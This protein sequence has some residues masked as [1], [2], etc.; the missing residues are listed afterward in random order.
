VQVARHAGALAVL[1]SA[2]DRLAV[3]LVEA[4]ELASAAA[5]LDEAHAVAGAIGDT[6]ISH[7][8]LVL[9][10]WRDETRTHDLVEAAV[11]EAAAQ[12]DGATATVAEYAIAVLENGVG[13]RDVALAAAR[14][15][16]EHDRPGLAARVLPELVEAAAR[17]GEP[18]LASAVLGQLCEATRASGTDYALGIEARTRALLADGEAADDLY[19]ESIVRLGRCRAGAQLAR[20]HLLYGE[21]LR[22]IDRRLDA[23]AQ[24]RSAR[25]LFGAMGADVFVR[26]AAY[27]LHAA[28]ESPRARAV[29][30]D[31]R[32]TAQEIR[33]AQLARDGLTN[34]EIGLEL[35]I[36]PRTVEY[37]L[38]KVFA[39]LAISSRNQLPLAL[40]ESAGAAPPARAALR[41]SAP[42]GRVAA[43]G[44]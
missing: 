41:L 8:A 24:L 6:G 13:R 19:R 12:G 20:A 21:W 38:H 36:S 22:S 35:S 37:H 14:Q 30:S 10:A 5:L 11:H 40:P 18:E 3:L 33:I 43:A 15:A 23:R 2:L 28:G 25:E 17:S 26:W 34:R 32:L 7:G 1:P 42:S 31:G 4:G 39:K 44:V 16:V 9:A 27:E 29:G